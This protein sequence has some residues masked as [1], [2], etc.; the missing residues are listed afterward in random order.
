MFWRKKRSLSDLDDE[1]KSHLAL[2]ADQLR[3][4]ADPHFDTEGAARRAFGNRT[5]LKEAFYEND[6]WLFWDR[7]SRDVRHAL[8]VCWRRPGFSAVVVATLAVGIGAT[9]AIFSVVN[10]VLLRPLPYKAP[11]RLAM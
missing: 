5:S 4:T 11:N 10:A 2:E 1:I 3:E 9:L 8:R 7:L 6:R